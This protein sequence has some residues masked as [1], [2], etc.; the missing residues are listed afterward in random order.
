MEAKGESKWDFGCKSAKDDKIINEGKDDC[1]EK[2]ES[3]DDKI[4][5]PTVNVSRIVLRPNG[6][7]EISSPLELR[8]NFDLD[9]DV[10]AGYWIIKFL[11]DSADKRIIRVPYIFVSRYISS[12][13]LFV[14]FFRY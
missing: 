3:S 14:F 13:F 11:V 2:W 4:D 10:I 8:I 6:P 9:R 1:E 5:P 7:T 12:F